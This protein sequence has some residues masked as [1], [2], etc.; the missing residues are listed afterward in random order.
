VPPESKRLPHTIVALVKDR[1]GVLSRVATC[2]A[3]QGWNIRSLAV[4]SS[5][6]AG[7]SRMTFV[8]DA[9]TDAAEMVSE[10][11]KLDDIDE[12]I[13]IS[14]Q[15]FVSRELALVRV[16]GGKE[17]RKRLMEIVD[18]FHA[19]ILDVA[20]NSMIIEVTGQENTIDSL[21]RLLKDYQVVELVRT[22]RVSMLRG[23]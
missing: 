17:A 6:Q 10:L 5:E 16:Q 19:S 18:I 23:N 2:C 1:P 13:D 22:G 12:I 8:V 14:A 21:V 20:P 11:N 15:E 7:M 4:G 9:S 3:E